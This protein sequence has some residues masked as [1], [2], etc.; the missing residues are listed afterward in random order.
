[1]INKRGEYKDDRT[2]S[3]HVKPVFRLLSNEDIQNYP[4]V[5]V[6]LSTT[7]SAE[8]H[9][10][11]QYQAGVFSHQIR[12]GILGAADVNLDKEITYDELAAYVSAANA[13]V[14]HSKAKLDIFVR[15]PSKN[16]S[17]PLFLLKRLSN[18][19]G[20]FLRLTTAEQ[21]KF[22]IET[23]EGVR[24][25]DFNKSNEQPLEI[26]LLNPKHFY[27]CSQSKRFKIIPNGKIIQASELIPSIQ[28][29]SSRQD[30]GDDFRNNLFQVPFGVSFYQGFMAS[31]DSKQNFIATFN[32]INRQKVTGVLDKTLSDKKSSNLS[33]LAYSSVS[34]AAATSVAA[35]ILYYLSDKKSDE[36][37]N[38]IFENASG[39]IKED[40][41]NM[42]ITSQVL[43]GVAG[44]AALSSIFFF[45]M[46]DDSANEPSSHSVIVPTIDSKSLGASFSLRF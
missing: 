19:S 21:G 20:G 7:T 2:G 14:R 17:A 1:L 34:L 25:A 15:P 37:K 13:K 24:Y 23:A 33:V 9:E 18:T 42:K 30:L 8:T 45:L 26:A 38:S 3:K 43:W 31:P 16:L 22:F 46:N 11:S 5:G 40:A 12:S 36:F 4:N 44:A 10:W 41:E 29:L 28:L 32:N 6:I 39:S 35:G 27:L